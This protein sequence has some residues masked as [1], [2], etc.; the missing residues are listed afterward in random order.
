[1]AQF[2]VLK[3]LSILCHNF[4]FVCSRTLKI[5]LISALR[6]LEM[7][8]L[9]P[10]RTVTA[11]LHWIKPYCRAPLCPLPPQVVLAL[12]RLR[13]EF[14]RSSIVSE[15]YFQLCQNIIS[16]VF[17]YYRKIALCLAEI[18]TIHL[19]PYNSTSSAG[20]TSPHL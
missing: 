1:M 14:Q 11:L 6:P 5:R 8:Y 16:Y 9:V 20:A 10:L 19:T 3:F 18:D 17:N 12:I 15:Y 13:F 7:R 2:R 4:S